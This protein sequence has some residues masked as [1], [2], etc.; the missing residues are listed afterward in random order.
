MVWLSR[1]LLILL[2]QAASAPAAAHS[3]STSYSVWEMGTQGQT[4]LQ[5]RL[6]EL[7]LTR[8]QL[9]PDYTPDFG[10]VLAQMLQR[11]LQ[12]FRAGSL[13]SYVVP[14]DW[15]R[16]AG[17]LL[18]RAELQCSA[19]GDYRLHSQLLLAPLPSHLHFA[20]LQWPDGSRLERVLTERD[21]EWL[22]SAGEAPSSLPGYWWLG[23][24]HILSGWDHLA[25]V[26]GLVL[27][28]G[29]LAQVAWLVTGFT[30]AHSLTLALAVLGWVQPA[31][32]VVEAM[33]ALSILLIAVEAA[34]QLAG[35][36]RWLPLL[37]TLGI[38]GLALLPAVTLPP[39]LLLGMAG[40]SYCYFRLIGRLQ[41][42][43]RLRAAIAF[44]FGLFHGFG[45]AGVLMQMNLPGRDLA[46]ALLGFN[47][48]VESG[49][50]MVVALAWPLLLWLGR[51]W[52]NL[53]GWATGGL[54][55]LGMYWF[56]LRAVA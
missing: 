33:I 56:V 49:Q 36:P 45:F 3:R 54:A 29:S 37:A 27:L 51:R 30:L 42:P 28:A 26:L 48:G 47:L 21:P 16:E 50:L 35:R 5:L 4:T 12:L 8:L 19:R 15:W 11:D 17:Q 6:T 2:L 20:Q 55:G 41:R 53:P 52:H 34:W 46:T 9:H 40:F 7:D 32:A 39:L 18:V 13:C 31:A 44:A 1:I 38:V 10:A 24:E 23:V 43:Y 14:L 22:F 25:F